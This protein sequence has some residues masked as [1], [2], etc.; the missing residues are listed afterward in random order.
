MSR[1]KTLCPVNRATGKITV[2][3][4]RDHMTEPKRTRQLSGVNSLRALEFLVDHPIGLGI[5]E[6]SRELEMD[7]SQCQRPPLGR[8]RHEDGL[9][10]AAISG[11]L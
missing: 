8:I 3:T 4:R 7:G 11:L 5:T 9:D 2:Y 10:R 1:V 6:M